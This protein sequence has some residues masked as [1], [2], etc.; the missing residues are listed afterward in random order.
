METLI[1]YL[2]DEDKPV[3]FAISLR[4]SFCA[5]IFDSL[6]ADSRT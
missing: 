6:S 2:T 1:A 4:T 5:A 3:K